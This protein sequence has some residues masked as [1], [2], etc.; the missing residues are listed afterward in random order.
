M[1]Y[2]NNIQLTN[3]CGYKNNRFLFSHNGSYNPISVFFGPN[4]SGKSAV[5]QAIRLVSN[6]Y[7]FFGRENDIFFRKLIW[8]K[9]YDPI[10]DNF[11]P[12]KNKLKIKANY[13][14]IDGKSY[15]SILDGKGIVKS[16][17]ERYNSNQEG[18]TI[19]CNADHPMNMNK[20]QLY[21]KNKDLFLDLAKSIYG[22]D[23]DLDK[24]VESSWIDKDTKEVIRF[25]QD[26]IL[27]KKDV[28]VHFRRMSD[29]EKKISTLIRFLCDEIIF[30]PSK[31]VLIDNVEMHIYFKRHPI[32]IDK[33]VSVFPDRQFIV[34]THSKTI[35]D[36]VKTS[37]GS[38]CL[39]DL[40]TI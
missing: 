30:N 12:S 40:E 37:F 5:I 38:H 27:T 8:N 36:H 39:Y 13:T 19:Y 4:G 32:L 14:D 35:V 7:Q 20:F 11:K 3:F 25:Y 24:E 2:L 6:P 31:I 10:V 29:G 15:S 16:S 26:V 34:T 33:L 28:S 17:L 21:S 9:D 22:L 23:V 1:Y 18:W